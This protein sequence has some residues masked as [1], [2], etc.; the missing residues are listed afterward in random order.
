MKTLFRTS[1]LAAAL[2]LSVFAMTGHAIV[3]YGTCRTFCSN[4]TTHT[5]TQVSWYTTQ[6]QCCNGSVNPCPPGTTPGGAS[7]QPTS[8]FA[9][10]CPAN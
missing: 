3:T 2:A 4:P 5:L 8:G 6:S 7:F 9:V 10:L 1:A